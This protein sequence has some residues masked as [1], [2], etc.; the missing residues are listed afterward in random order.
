MEEEPLRLTMVYPHLWFYDQKTD[1]EYHIG[2]LC[3][4]IK[5][6]GYSE[7]GTMQLDLTKTRA[8]MVYTDEVAERINH[9]SNPELGSNE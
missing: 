5:L 4:E 7:D 2:Q 9:I 1:T 3:V 6:L 8:M